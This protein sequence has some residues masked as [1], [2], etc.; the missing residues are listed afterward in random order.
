MDNTGFILTFL[1]DLELEM[2]RIGLRSAISLKILK[3]ICF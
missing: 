1:R 3:R 2:R